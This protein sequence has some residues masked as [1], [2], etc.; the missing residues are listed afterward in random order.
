ML[1]SVTARPKFQTHSIAALNGFPWLSNSKTR[2][3]HRPP[4]RQN[5]YTLA[6]LVVGEFLLCYG[7]LILS[8]TMAYAALAFFVLPFAVSCAAVFSPTACVAFCYSYF[9]GVAFN[10]KYVVAILNA[11]CI[12]RI[13]YERCPCPCRTR[14]GTPTG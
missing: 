11:K 7:P 10:C 9:H 1:C 12:F 3:L 8:C 14:E 5:T 4:C 6:S 13:I 2:A